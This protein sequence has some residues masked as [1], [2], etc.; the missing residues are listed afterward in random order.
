[1]EN[2]A[3]TAIRSQEKERCGTGG[4]VRACLNGLREPGLAALR[5]VLNVARLW[6][7]ITV[8]PSIR[9]L[10]GEKN[11]E[12]VLSHTEED[13]YL[14]KAPLLLREFATVMLDTGMRPEEVCR[15]RW[16]T[17]TWNR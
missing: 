9:L 10:P 8:V 6:K 11:H 17:F 13:L 4:H 2:Q 14:A 16:E 7:L 1:M 15:M 5:R 3:H 12:R